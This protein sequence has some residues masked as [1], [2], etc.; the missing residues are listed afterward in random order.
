MYPSQRYVVATCRSALKAALSAP[1]D[2]TLPMTDPRATTA[3][4]TV[5]RPSATAV[6]KNWLELLC[7]DVLAVEKIEKIYFDES[8]RALVDWSEG[9]SN[10]ESEVAV[11]DRP[12]VRKMLLLLTKWAGDPTLP[13]LMPRQ[14][15]NGE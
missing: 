10:G 11:E 1:L 4:H 14:R 6:D 9:S 8:T 3:I 5:I 7:N 12:R 13:W 15:Q 2:P